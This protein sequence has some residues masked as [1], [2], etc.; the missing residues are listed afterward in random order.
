M[1]NDNAAFVFYESFLKNIQQVERF[2]G[3]EAAYDYMMDLIEYGLYGLVPD[4]NSI[5]WLYGFEHMRDSI[6]IAQNRRE[7]QIA[8][9]KMGGRPRKMVDIKE[10]LFLKQQG[11]SLRAIS[12]KL[13][14]SEKT[15]RRRIQEYEQFQNDN[16]DKTSQD[17]FVPY[18]DKTPLNNFILTQQDKTPITSFDRSMGHNPVSEFCPN[19][20]KSCSA[21]EV[22][23]QQDKTKH[24]GFDPIGQNPKMSFDRKTDKSPGSFD[25][26][27]QNLQTTCLTH[28][29]SKHDEK[30]QVDTDKT[31]QK[32]KTGQNLKEKV[33][34]KEKDKNSLSGCA[35]SIGESDK[36]HGFNFDRGGTKLFDTTFDQTK[37]DITPYEDFVPMTAEQVKWLRERGY[38]V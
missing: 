33:K 20:D 38:N 19:R 5:T 36:T 37:P 34:E 28:S 18:A 10:I 2:Q 27:G 17:N 9:G 15:A 1:A 29:S 24:A 3:K 21:E 35:A 7:K 11:L 31:G 6:D 8:Q 12:D 14:I 4:E 13:H 23:T 30:N 22:L 32:D 26:V 16:T 25:P